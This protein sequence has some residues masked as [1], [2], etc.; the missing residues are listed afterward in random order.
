MNLYLVPASAE[1]LAA[2]IYHKVPLEVLDGIVSSHEQGQISN[3]Q[4]IKDGFHCWAFPQGKI[5]NWHDM[6]V[7]DI[8]LITPKQTGKFQIAGRAIYKLQSEVLGNKLWPFVP[9]EPW[10]NI[11]LLGTL[12]NIDLEKKSFLTHVCGYSPRFV[13]PGS[14]RVKGAHLEQLLSKYKTLENFWMRLTGEPAILSV[15]S[16]PAGPVIMSSSIGDK[17]QVYIVPG[18]LEDLISYIGELMK[19]TNSKERGNESLVERFF[20]A[21]GYS[22]VSEIKYRQGNVDIQIQIDDAPIAV[23]E[24]KRSWSLT[25]HDSKILKQAFGYAGENGARV[26]VI[27]NGDYYAIFDRDRDGLSFDDY[28]FGEFRLTRLTDECLQFIDWL[29]RM[30]NLCTQK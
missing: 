19:D 14:I 5:G 18:Y 16:E 20:E 11:Y 15:V 26:V 7:G 23:I 28:F 24:V 27:T 4:E 1:N 17:E 22:P 8:V 30:R 10:K 25:R 13:V 12:A 21:L 29:K 6:R 2:T 3:L 9:G